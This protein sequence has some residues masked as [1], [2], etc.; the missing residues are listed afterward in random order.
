MG[1]QSEV[2][3]Q[4]SILSKGEKT[5]L[6]WLANRLPLWVTPDML[7][8][9][10][11]FGSIM[12]GAGYFFS[13]WGK[14]FLWLSSLGFIVNWFGDSLDG[15]VARVR[16]IERPTYGFY[17][18]HN[19]DAMTAVIIVIGAGTS[20]FLTLSVVILVLIGYLLLSIFTYINTYLVG[21]LKISYSGLGPTELR[22]VII[23]INTIFYFL[24][25]ENT[26]LV[27]N[28][29]KLKFFD[30][31]ALFVAFVLLTLYFYYFFAEKKKYEKVDPPKNKI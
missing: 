26:I 22:L 29:F 9:I 8:A 15:T 16:K 20:P 13:N 28:G 4:T 2:R 12:S 1:K 23:I 17:I 11:F 30:L 10:G 6:I 7:T 14:G 27:F 5:L 18:D 31:F 19:V 3:I 25:M 24:P 21:V